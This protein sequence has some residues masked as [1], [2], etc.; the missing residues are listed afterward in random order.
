MT[1]ATTRPMTLEEYLNYDDGTETR[2]ELVD[3]VLVEMGAETDRNVLIALFLLI[4]FSRLLP[5]VQLRRG[6]EVEISEGIATS[7]CPDLLVLTEEGSTA[8]PGDQRSRITLEMPAPALVVE[9]VSPGEPGEQNYDRD[10]IEKRREYALRGIPEYW[11]ID[12]NRQII[13][14]LTLQGQTYQEQQFVGT[15]VIASP[16]FP[17]LTLTV[18]QI[19]TAG[20]D[21]GIAS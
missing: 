16:T 1:I 11:I 21:T 4:M 19:L 12:P 7:R 18:N 2:Y 9:V 20:K 3:G 13:L 17:K 6:T 14:I 5:L 8:L 15:E 10:Y